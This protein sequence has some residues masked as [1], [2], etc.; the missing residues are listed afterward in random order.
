MEIKKKQ[1]L[2]IGWIIATPLT[3]AV[4]MLVIG[5]S[6]FG[7]LAE[8]QIGDPGLMMFVVLLFAAL[9]TIGSLYLFYQA[10]AIRRDHHRR[11]DIAEQ[12][13]AKDLEAFL[14]DQTNN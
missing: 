3:L 5:V 7:L 4:I 14:D 11:A 9:F 13:F 6:L 12:R 8:D 10:A 2:H 1:P